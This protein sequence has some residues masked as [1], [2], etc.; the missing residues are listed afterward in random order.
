MKLSCLQ[1]AQVPL[2]I[3]SPLLAIL[4]FVIAGGIEVSDLKRLTHGSG[5][6]RFPDQ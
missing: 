1:I 2:T 5:R 4:N 6:E 3:V